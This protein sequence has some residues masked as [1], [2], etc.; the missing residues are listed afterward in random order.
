MPGRATFP[1]HEWEV[2][3]G[4]TSITTKHVLGAWMRATFAPVYACIM[5]KHAKINSDRNITS[6]DY[7]A[8]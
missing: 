5:S 7:A 4:P 1:R 6:M 2:K 3:V 8:K